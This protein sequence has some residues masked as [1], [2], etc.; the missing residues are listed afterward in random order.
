MHPILFKIGPLPIHSYG[1]MLAL[2]FLLGIWLGGLRCKRR[3]L[4]GDVISDVGFWVIISAI[5]GSRLYYV[6][7]HFEE[8]EGDLLGII[9]PFHGGSTGIGGL[10]MYGGY[11]GAI[12]AGLL[13]FKLKKLPFL[14]YA[15]ATA[16]T[17]GIGIFL[18]RIG[19]FLNGCCFGAA[20]ES[21]VGMHFPPSSPAG[22]YQLHI[23]AGALYPSQLFESAG[24]LAIAAII[25]L[26]GRKRI[27]NGFEFFLTGLL[28]S[29]L[30]FAIDFTRYYTPQEMMLGMTHNQI[31]CIGIFIVFGGLML[32]NFIGEVSQEAAADTHSGP[33]EPSGATVGK[34][35]DT[36]ENA[37]ERAA[38]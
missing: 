9:N 24:G 19:C 27:F 12:L 35:G 15:D 5:L 33:P 31:V 26:V 32:K 29:V 37:G 13:Y 17:I 38:E 3:G 28:Y 11:I 20:T 10:V 8:F 34:L 25:L 30:R 7:L 14:P 4:D 18:T 2:S 21:S 23:H 36:E 16:P 6:V 22:Q 1:F